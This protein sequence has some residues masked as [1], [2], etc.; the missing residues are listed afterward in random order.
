M[1]YPIDVGRIGSWRSLI[2]NL[3]HNLRRIVRFK[4]NP[5]NEY[6]KHWALFI[7]SEPTSCFG[8]WYINM[9]AIV[10]P[11][12]NS[13]QYRMHACEAKLIQVSK[14]GQC[15]IVISKS[16]LLVLDIKSKFPIWN[17]W[18]RRYW[19]RI[20]TYSDYQLT[21]PEPCIHET[22]QDTFGPFY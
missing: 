19:Q 14:M 20:T 7:K 17:N 8:H 13:I 6:V 22:G 16:N 5:L 10:F 1:R 12:L 15:K 18:M 11:V 2:Q 4:R 3:W 21:V 9:H